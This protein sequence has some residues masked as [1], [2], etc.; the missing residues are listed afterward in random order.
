MSTKG[1]SLVELT[2]RFAD[3]DECR[4]FLAEL[5][6][7]EG[8]EC[9]ECQSKSVSFLRKRNQYDCNDCRRRFSVKAGTIFNDS[10]LPL[11]KW[12]LAVFIMCESKKGVSA[13]QLKRMLGVTYKTAWYLCHRI[14]AAMKDKDQEPLIGTIEI[15]ETYVGGEKRGEG[16]GYVDN[17]SVVIAAVSRGGEMRA[18]V[19]PDRRKRSVRVFIAENVDGKA[20]AI[21]TDEAQVY[22]GALKGR[23]NHESVRH[24]LAYDRHSGKMRREWVRGDVHTNTVEGVHSL[25]KRS[26]IG[27]YH[28]LSMKHLPAYVDEIEWRYNNRD[29]EYLF[30]DTLLELVNAEPLE[31][32]RL[33]A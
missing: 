22:R 17:K 25:L 1:L 33:V 29:N 23:E 12:F 27:S 31:Y 3:E 15:D 6:W 9:P 14:R 19:L 7:P 16:S 10:K 20:K 4:E 30:R 24:S 28:H 2:D 26:I 11:R 8:V 13:N 18:R 5:R 32:K 21:Y